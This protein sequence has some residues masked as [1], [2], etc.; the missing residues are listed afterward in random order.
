M[1]D[2]PDPWRA[3]LRSP[4]NIA[5]T[6]LTFCGVIAAGA[7][8]IAI[9]ESYSNLLAFARVYGLSG[10]RAGI[11]PGAVDSFIIIGELLLFG[12]ILLHAGKPLHVLGIALA[13]WGFLLSTGGNVWHAHT[14]IAADRAVSAIWPVTATAGLA[15]T[16]MIVRQ[17]TTARRIPSPPASPRSSEPRRSSSPR[18]AASQPGKRAAAQA[19]DQ[20]RVQLL[21][22]SGQELPTARAYGIAEHITRTRAGAIVGQARAAMNGSSQ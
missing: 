19:A 11:A 15:V 8:V 20:A 2:T 1:Q 14:A 22:E 7:T 17:A 12:A 6:A 3:W 21:L 5:W 16:A 9:V 4:G 18:R 13:A 10:W